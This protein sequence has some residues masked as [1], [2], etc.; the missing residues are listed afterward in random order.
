MV[1]RS[2][3]LTRNQNK[4]W[5]WELQSFGEVDEIHVAEYA[6]AEEAFRAAQLKFN[7]LYSEG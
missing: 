7:E 4:T 5:S 6:T 3:V 1:Y 2:I